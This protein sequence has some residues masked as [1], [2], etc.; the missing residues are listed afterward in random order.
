LIWQNKAKENIKLNLFLSFK[1]IKKIILKIQKLIKSGKPNFGKVKFRKDEILKLYP[2]I[3]KVKKLIGWAPKE[4][5][6]KGIIKTI[7]FYKKNSLNILNT[8]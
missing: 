2:S 6:E 4:R 3:K 7:N 1:K 5:F 8:I